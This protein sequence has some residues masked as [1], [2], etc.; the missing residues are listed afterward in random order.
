MTRH[1][2]LKTGLATVAFSSIASANVVNSI[3]SAKANSL[4]SSSG[5]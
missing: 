3:I 5:S 2:F 1:D 4:M